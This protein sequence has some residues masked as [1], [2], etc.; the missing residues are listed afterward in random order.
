MDDDGYTIEGRYYKAKTKKEAM[1]MHERYKKT[2]LPTWMTLE[3]L[4]RDP[5]SEDAGYFALEEKKR[6]EG[7]NNI[8]TC[9]TPSK[10]MRP[11]LTDRGYVRAHMFPLTPAGKRQAVKKEIE[12]REN[13]QQVQ[14]HR[15]YCHDAEPKGNYWTVWVQP[16]LKSTRESAGGGG[17]GHKSGGTFYAR[18]ARRGD[19]RRQATA[20]RSGWYQYRP[21]A[22]AVSCPKCNA[23]VGLTCVT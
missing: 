1:R 15:M 7:R 12:Y 21:E 8:S 4:G 17:S 13:S 10:S 9:Q 2:Q 19:E 22:R 14:V 3:A 18:G 11:R 6:R 5:A 23:P 16:Y 20:G